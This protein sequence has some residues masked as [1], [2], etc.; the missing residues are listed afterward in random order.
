[1]SEVRIEETYD[2]LCTIVL[3]SALVISDLTRD[4]AETLAALYGQRLGA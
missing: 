4:E 2:G 3:G 1:M